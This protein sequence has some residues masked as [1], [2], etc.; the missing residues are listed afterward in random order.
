MNR[1]NLR[2]SRITA[3]RNLLAKTYEIKR[4]FVI[5]ALIGRKR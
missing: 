5:K 3:L 4:V 2:K 1:A